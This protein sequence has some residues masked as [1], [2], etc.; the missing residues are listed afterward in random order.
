MQ[1]VPSTAKS[2]APQIHQWWER[3]SSH[4]D[5]WSHA[6]SALVVLIITVLVSGWVSDFVKRLARRMTANEADRTLPEFLSQVVRWILL[7][8]GL[9]VFLNKLG[10]ETTSFVTVLGAA[11]LSIGLALQNTLGNTAA[12]LMILFTKPYRI[13]DSI[14]TGETKGRVHRLGIFT[15]EVDNYDNIRVYVPNAKVFAAEIQNLTTNGSLKLELKV[16]VGYE[17]DLAQ[18]QAIVSEVVTRQPL[19]LPSHDIWVGFNAFGD[20]GVDLRVQMWV[21]PANVQNA[22]SALILDIKQ[23]FDAAGIDIPY[24]HQVAIA[25]AVPG[26]ASS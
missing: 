8:L 23:A 14:I 2:P 12:G 13:G 11:S 24:P 1:L 10:V 6:L 5:A 16:L 9:V 3:F 21:M 20:S 4:P 25:K 18:V 17:A 22:R 15:T 19:R 7:T 26:D